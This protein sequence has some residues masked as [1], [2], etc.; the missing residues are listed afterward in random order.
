VNT[1]IQSLIGLIIFSCGLLTL[2]LLE[3]Y[4]QRKLRIVRFARA[5][6][7]G[8]SSE[9]GAAFALARAI[10][11]GVLRGPDPVFLTRMLIPLGASP[12]SVL[13]EGGCCSGIHRLFITCLDAIGIRSAQITIYSQGPRAVH[14]L[15]QVETGATRVI[16]DVDYG[17][18][19]KHPAGGAIGLADLQAGVSPTIERFELHSQAHSVGEAEAP[20]P[21]GYPAHEYYQFDFSLTRT[22][23][24]TKSPIRRS[25]YR[26]LHCL[27]AGRVDC[28][29]LPPI[30]EWPEVLLAAAVTAVALVGAT[31][32]ALI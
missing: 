15:V 30:L 28:L 18:W 31:A 12:A 13:D 32:Y 20:R 4:R 11:S 5:A 22:A 8:C 7:N 25:I 19:L 2:V 27:T 29:L 6:T 10:F 14:C 21:A 26:A 1:A 17:V 9:L 16:I 23:N 3:M 24:W